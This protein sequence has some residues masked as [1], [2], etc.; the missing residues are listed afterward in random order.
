MLRK[1]KKKIEKRE[2]IWNGK[3]ER[4]IHVAGCAACNKEGVKIVDR[5][6][7]EKEKNP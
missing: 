7:Y 2:R 5:I 6:R 4:K 3:I 1:Q